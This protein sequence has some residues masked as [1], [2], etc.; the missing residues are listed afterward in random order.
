MPPANGPSESARPG[1]GPGRGR[2]PGGARGASKGGSRRPGDGSRPGGRAGGSARGG[3]S[4]R[5]GRRTPPPREPEDAGEAGPRTWGSLARKGARR[6]SDDVRGAGTAAP[7]ERRPAERSEEVWIDEGPVRDAATGAVRRGRSRQSTSTPIDASV[8]G[9]AKAVGPKD[10]A[11]FEARLRDAA[12][13]FERERY[14][15]ARGALVALAERMPANAAVRELL[16]L[17]YYRLGR[18]K[19]AVTEL[20]AFRELSGSTE[21]HPVLADCYR[22]LRRWEAVEALWDELREVSP[23]AELV[24]EG[25]IVTAGALAD[26]DRLREAIALLDKGFRFPKSPQEH[27]LRRAYALADLRE[28]SGDLP[29]ARSLFER[30]AALDPDFGDVVDRVRALR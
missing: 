17:T 10:A 22:A 26:R 6:L 12:R 11:R 14:G 29:Q 16:G 3:Q 8:A 9:V 30:I 27:H 5:S 7:D 4:P 28:R 24:T 2:P 19:L 1:R 13:A 18:W 23:S 21:Q 15:E 25:R 20:E